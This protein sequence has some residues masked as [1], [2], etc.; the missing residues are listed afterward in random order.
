[1]RVEGV[2]VRMVYAFGCP[3]WGAWEDEYEFRRTRDSRGLVRDSCF[4][5][6]PRIPCP[7]T[8]GGCRFCDDPAIRLV[9]RRRIH[10]DHRSRY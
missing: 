1:M 2:P 4:L 8:A 7:L 6:G 10:P 9:G 3:N 5:H